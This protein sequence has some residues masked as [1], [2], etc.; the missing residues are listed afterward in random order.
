[1]RFLKGIPAQKEKIGFTGQPLKCCSLAVNCGTQ[2][3]GKVCLLCRR[4]IEQG[5]TSHADCG[6]CKPTSK[7]TSRT[8][9][10]YFVHAR[11]CRCSCRC[12][13]RCVFCVHIVISKWLLLSGYISSPKPRRQE[14]N[15]AARAGGQYV[16]FSRDNPETTHMSPR[17]K[18]NIP[19]YFSQG[20]G[21]KQPRGKEAKALFELSHVREEQLQRQGGT[22]HMGPNTKTHTTSHC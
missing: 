12:S 14:T 11:L 7:G 18:L 5:C 19:R 22:E 17:F 21:C 4:L 3:V 9:W 16:P 10:Q 1:M 2:C 8:E 13:R 15:M 6:T 20:F